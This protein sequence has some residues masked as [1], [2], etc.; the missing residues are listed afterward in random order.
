[1]EGQA[2]LLFL[3]AVV[4]DN[5]ELM[6]ELL[7]RFPLM[8]KPDLTDEELRRIY[9]PSKMCNHFYVQKDGSLGLVLEDTPASRALALQLNL[10]K[11]IFWGANGDPVTV[12]TVAKGVQS[13]QH[14]EQYVAPSKIIAVLDNVRAEQQ[15]TEAM[16]AIAV[17]R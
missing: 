17:R 3:N 11:H 7:Q 2:L 9:V 4:R 6:L 13:M 14:L 5:A 10:E 15:A 8:A 16:R 12:V 1:M